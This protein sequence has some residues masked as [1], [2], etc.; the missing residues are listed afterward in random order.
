MY[1]MGI[2][3]HRLPLQDPAFLSLRR[4]HA[5]TGSAPLDMIG[6]LRFVACPAHSKQQPCFGMN[7]GNLH[8]SFILRRRELPMEGLTSV[9]STMQ[10]KPRAEAGVHQPFLWLTRWV[11]I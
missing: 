5:Q 2:Q 6:S 8:L 7:H 3:W 1:L 9:L 10:A 4:S 11:S